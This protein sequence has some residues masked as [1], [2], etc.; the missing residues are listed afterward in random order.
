MQHVYN[1]MIGFDDDSSININIGGDIGS[2]K[3]MIED[4]MNQVYYD[5]T[6]VGGKPILSDWRAID[7]LKVLN[8]KYD[9]TPPEFVTMVIT[10]TGIIPPTSAPVIIREYHK[11][12]ELS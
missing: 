1:V 9:L 10:E 11:D 8:L 2:D 3:K 5:Y 7:G 4:E 12:R 6:Q